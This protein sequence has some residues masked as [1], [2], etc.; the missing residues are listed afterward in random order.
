MPN[1]VLNPGL[2]PD[3]KPEP[4]PGMPAPLKKGKQA[5]GHSEEDVLQPQQR[6]TFAGLLLPGMILFIVFFIGS[7][8]FVVGYS[9]QRFSPTEGTIDG[10]TLDNYQ[11]AL[12]DE[13]IHNIF[14][15]TIRISLVVTGLG[16][17][18]AYPVA[19]ALSRIEGFRRTLLF[20]LVI[21]PLFISG[22]I[23]AFAWSQAMVRPGII[24][25]VLIWLG[26]IQTTGRLNLLY[27]EAAVIIGL[28]EVILPFI[29]L[30][31]SSSIRKQDP[32]LAS[33]AQSLGANPLVTF[34]RVTFPLSL[35]GLVAGTSLSFIICMGSYVTPDLLGGPR[36]PV[37]A[38]EVYRQVNYMSDWSLGGALA[39]ILL[40]FT[41]TVVSL[42]NR[43]LN[44][45]G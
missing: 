28:L 22:V 34:W 2:P 14:G 44:G 4:N 39:F 37:M 11:K 9:F 24:N 8:I 12:S 7:F 16:V 13:S 35:P 15:R 3:F 19:L 36:L 31:L 45:K 33:A 43:L 17:L 21:S 23:R 6:L 25:E 32:A 41:M 1:K 10:F 18:L 20:V 27:T 38:T 29:I 42:Y 30:P 40:A 26:V 5:K